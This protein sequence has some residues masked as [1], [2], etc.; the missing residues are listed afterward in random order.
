M[1]SDRKVCQIQ[2][3]KHSQKLPENNLRR[4][5]GYMEAE[6]Y[7]HDS[8]TKNREIDPGFV[9]SFARNKIPPIVSTAFTG[10][11][12]IWLLF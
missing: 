8:V 3:Q 1:K 4:K 6:L 7:G 9:Y 11:C 2:E 12:I 5:T 10:S